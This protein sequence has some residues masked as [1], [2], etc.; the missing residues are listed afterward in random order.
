[1]RK[2]DWIDW[3]AYL[4]VRLFI[5]VIQAL[6]LENVRESFPV[7]SVVGFRCAENSPESC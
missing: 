5:A 3:F 1:M 6:P 7:P 4:G 2:K